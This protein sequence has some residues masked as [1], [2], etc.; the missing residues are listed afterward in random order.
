MGLAKAAND[1]NPSYILVA[2][3]LPGAAVALVSAERIL[4]AGCP[5]ALAAKVAKTPDDAMSNRLHIATAVHQ[6]QCSASD[7]SRLCPALAS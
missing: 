7:V 3:Q 1:Q 4:F 6:I 5:Q 2:V